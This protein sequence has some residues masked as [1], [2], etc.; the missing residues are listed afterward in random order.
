MLMAEPVSF[1]RLTRRKDLAEAVVGLAARE[2]RAEGERVG[3]VVAALEAEAAPAAQE[4][5]AERVGRAALAEQEAKVAPAAQE[6]QAEE[7]PDAAAAGPL[8]IPT[9]TIPIPFIRS[10]GPSFRRFRP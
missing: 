8:R 1:W 5:Q 6:E 2:E 9:R 4:E 10:Q 3:P 7:R